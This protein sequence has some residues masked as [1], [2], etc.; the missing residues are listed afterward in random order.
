[1]TK[2]LENKTHKNMTGVGETFFLQG[3]AV[4][5]RITSSWSLLSDGIRFELQKMTLV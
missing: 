3:R 4:E 2:G 1:M 5:G